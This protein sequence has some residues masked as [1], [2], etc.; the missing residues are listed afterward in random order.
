M[1]PESCR[2]TIKR[3]HLRPDLNCDSGCSSICANSDTMVAEEEAAVTL[4]MP[5]IVTMPMSRFSILRCFVLFVAVVF[6]AAGH[7][8]FPCLMAQSQPV[9]PDSAAQEVKRLLE[10]LDASMEE[11]R[12]SLEKGDYRAAQL[13]KRNTIEALDRLLEMFLP[14][15][16]LIQRLW[17]N[18]QAIADQ[19]RQLDPGRQDDPEERV[20]RDQLS[21]RQ[22]VNLQKTR[23]AVLAVQ[24]SLQKASEQRRERPDLKAA[25]PKNPVQPPVELLQ[26]V[27]QLLRQAGAHQAA[28]VQQL[29]DQ[30]LKEALTSE[31]RAAEKLEEAFKALQQEPQDQPQRDGQQQTSPQQQNSS[32]QNQQAQNQR[33]SQEK[34]GGS[35]PDGSGGSPSM[36]QQDGS[37]EAGPE[38]SLTPE[39]ALLELKRLQKEAEA[40]K[41]RRERAL[42]SLPAPGRVPIEKDW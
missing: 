19:T 36:E 17:R 11:S 32:Q 20:V 39:E 30:R 4:N 1:T 40:E 8:V 9:M 27:Q 14:L 42:G 22:A 12:E 3:L 2:N 24:D 26:T 31:Q 18:Q 38:N 7:A 28:A 23:A 6:M 34:A 25:E 35:D 37:A 33:N 41:R 5:A 13:E 15:P 29:R 16:D 10:Q 21:D